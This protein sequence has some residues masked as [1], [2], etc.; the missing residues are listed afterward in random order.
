M[1]LFCKDAGLAVSFGF[2]V[3]EQLIS[4]SIVCDWPDA[5]AV[6]NLPTYIDHRNKNIPQLRQLCFKPPGIVD[7]RKRTR[8]NKDSLWQFNIL[9]PRQPVYFAHIFRLDCFSIFKGAIDYVLRRREEVF[10]CLR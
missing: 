10:R 2:H 1:T 4:N 8:L 7:I 5:N 9:W 6:E 3:L